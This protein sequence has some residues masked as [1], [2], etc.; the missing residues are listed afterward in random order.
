MDISDVVDIEALIP[1]TF[2]FMIC[3][4]IR[5]HQYPRSIEHQFIIV[6]CELMFVLY[7]I[8]TALARHV[9]LSHSFLI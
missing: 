2:S 3:L 7:G 1:T 9:L 4:L 6:V 8:H 5:E